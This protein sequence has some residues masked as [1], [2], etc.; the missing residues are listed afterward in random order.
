MVGHPLV[1]T[2]RGFELFNEVL[3]KRSRFRACKVGLVAFD[4]ADALFEVDQHLLDALDPQ[5]A[6]AF[7]N[8]RRA[9]NKR[10]RDEDEDDGEETGQRATA[11]PSPA[12]K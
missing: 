7:E 1:T 11:K 5:D 3:T 12:P 2:P 4:K 6:K 9:L 8:L 10:G